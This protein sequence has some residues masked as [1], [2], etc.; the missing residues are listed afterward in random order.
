MTAG[1]SGIDPAHHHKKLEMKTK[2]TLS[3]TG[4]LAATTALTLFCT[5]ARADGIEPLTAIL[6]TP[7]SAGMGLA[8]RA[9]TSPYL[10]GGTRYDLVPIYLYEGER[11]FLHANRAGV[12]LFNDGTDKDGQRVDLFVEQRFEGF[13]SDRLPPSLAGMASR[14]SG[15]DL[16]LA[17]RLRQPWGT[18]RAELTRDV[19]SASRGTEARLGYSYEWRSGPWSLRPDVSVSWRD[20]KLNDYYYGVRA[21]EATP[22]RAAYA[23]GSGMQSQLGLYGSYD[24]SQRWR[25]LAGVSATVLGSSVKN[26]P[27]VDKRVLPAVYI[28]ASYR[29]QQSW[30]TLRAE[31]FK[32]VGNAVRGSEAR[33]GYSNE[34][35]SGSWSVRPDVSVSWRDAKLNNYYYG[36]MPSEAITGRPA[37]APGAGFQSQLGLFASYDMTQRWRFLTG[38]SLT[39]LGSS[40]KESPI[41]QKRMVPAV[42][43]G[44]SYDFGGPQVKSANS[45]NSAQSESPTY[46]KVLY[47]M[48][49]ENSC[50][51]ARIIT[52]RCLST[53][54][55]N[56]T[57]VTG[58]QL[59]KPFIQGLNGWPLDFAGY[60]GLTYH[61]E[62]GLQANGAQLDVFMKAIYYGFPWSDRVKTR[63][64]L[65][66]GLSAAQRVPYTEVTSQNGKTTS[67]LLN[68]L[69]PTIDISV[70]DVL[71]VRS[72]KETFVGFGVSHRSGIFGASRLLGNVS[73]GSNY[74]Y[75]YVE[76]AF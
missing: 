11:L 9:T 76:S 7:G 27:I 39:L 53:A 22:G 5:F 17:Y 75:T 36:V 28:G 1:S 8:V 24:L 13:P 26:S 48:A 50:H 38:A 58:V 57:N 67:R 21:N 74:I 54:K 10:G 46:I 47:G 64:G 34:W 44:A 12:K 3:K 68:Y 20:A 73:G 23:P 15:L 14:D 45:A 63:L 32:G 51:L 72:L 19:G 37:Y 43:V 6:N 60:V 59:G 42:Y 16:G 69:D 62:R 33:F 56:A 41:V 70:G 25:L 35:R 49:T 40:V 66:V 29:L 4:L 18:L 2:T 65:G 71:G 31:V 30:G 52:A 61:N 55:V